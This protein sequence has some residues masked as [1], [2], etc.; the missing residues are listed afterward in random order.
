MI[1]FYIHIIEHLYTITICL[2]IS[3]NTSFPFHFPSFILLF[4][5]RLMKD[6][7]EALNGRGKTVDKLQIHLQELLLKLQ[8]RKG[9]LGTC[10][11]IYLYNV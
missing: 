5:S 4:F 10:G 8:V 1:I 7:S 9:V 3:H 6:L 2:S 11:L